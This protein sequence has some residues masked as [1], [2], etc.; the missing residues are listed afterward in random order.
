MALVLGFCFSV[1]E[2]VVWFW[3][4][5]PGV[6]VMTIVVLPLTFASIPN[7]PTTGM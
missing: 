4:V 6:V 3:A 7:I 2:K 5:M 1:W